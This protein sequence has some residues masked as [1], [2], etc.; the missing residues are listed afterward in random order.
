MTEIYATDRVLE[1]SLDNEYGYTVI[2]TW[3]HTNQESYKSSDTEDV[4]S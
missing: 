2:V 1:N 4:I 3:I